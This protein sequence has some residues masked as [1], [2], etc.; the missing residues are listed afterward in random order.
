MKIARALQ[1]ADE[2]QAD[3]FWH[4]NSMSM[5]YLIVSFK[6]PRKQRALPTTP[7][8][9]WPGKTGGITDFSKRVLFH[10]SQHEPTCPAP[11]D[12][13]PLTVLLIL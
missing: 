10:V 5:R 11:G 12:T 9:S 3:C 4:D 13:G 2:G 7:R 1:R 6:A 8:W